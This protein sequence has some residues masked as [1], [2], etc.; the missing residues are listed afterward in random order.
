LPIPDAVFADKQDESVRVCDLFGEL[1][2]PEAAGPQL[3]GRE[4]NARLRVLAFDGGLARPASFSSG[5]W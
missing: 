3:F 2:R 5:E 1:S 4:E